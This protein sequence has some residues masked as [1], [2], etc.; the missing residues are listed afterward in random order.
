MGTSVY[1]VI[2]GS[3][4]KAKFPIN[5]NAVSAMRVLDV[6]SMVPLLPIS[7]GNR[8]SAQCPSGLI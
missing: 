5:R 1:F 2:T 3:E 8:K 4:D 7:T 6:Q